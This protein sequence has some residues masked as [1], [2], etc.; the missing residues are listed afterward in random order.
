MK[1][2]SFESKH[3]SCNPVFAH[4]TRTKTE[5]IPLFDKTC[6]QFLWPPSLK[7][8]S[9]RRFLSSPTLVSFDDVKK[10][11][12]NRAPYLQIFLQ[13]WKTLLNNSPFW[14]LDAEKERE[15]GKKIG[16]PVS[17]CNV[18]GHDSKTRDCPWEVQGFSTVGFGGDQRRDYKGD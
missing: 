15:R 6:T 2:D 4:R 16:V 1:T 18:N 5:A 12:S 13:R 11:T 9:T 17:D 8:A 14:D 3:L 10:N 7:S